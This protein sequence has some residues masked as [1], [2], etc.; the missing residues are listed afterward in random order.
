[1]RGK[2]VGWDEHPRI[3]E[4]ILKLLNQELDPYTNSLQE[5][6]VPQIQRALGS[7]SHHLSRALTSQ[8]DERYHLEFEL[9]SLGLK[10]AL[11]CTGIL[12][13]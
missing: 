3:R 6:R 7:D 10:F 2:K 5:K 1:M 13:N 9:L 4:V 11:F 8:M 12:I